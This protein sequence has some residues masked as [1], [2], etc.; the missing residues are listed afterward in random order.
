MIKALSI[1]NEN[2]GFPKEAIKEMKILK[3]E[4]F[5]HKNIIKLYDIKRCK[6]KEKNNYKGFVYMIYENI[7]L[8]LFNYLNKGYK[9]SLPEIKCI[10][11]QILEG[12]EFLHSN[13]ICQGNLQISNILISNEGIVKIADF[14]YSEFFNNNKNEYN[15]NNNINRYNFSYGSQANKLDKNFLDIMKLR[16]ISPEVLLGED[17]STADIDIWALGCLIAELILE[18]PL[19]NGNRNN[20]LFIINH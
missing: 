7:E 10:L 11:L 17:K 19:F 5:I 1:D 4:K 2:E 3:Q 6:P 18:K 9:L 12:I 15:Y 20:Q 16:Y 13:N 14:S 8:D